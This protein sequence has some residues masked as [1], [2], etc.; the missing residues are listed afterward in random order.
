MVNQSDLMVNHSDWP[1]LN[2]GNHKSLWLTIKTIIGSYGSE[3]LIP[4]AYWPFGQP[5][6]GM[7]EIYP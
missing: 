2:I 3:W 5:W 6:F 7:I 4:S 1:S